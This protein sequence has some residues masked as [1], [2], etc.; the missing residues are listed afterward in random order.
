[1]NVSINKDVLFQILN[2]NLTKHKKE[3]EEAVKVWR[4]KFAV[5]INKTVDRINNGEKPFRFYSQLPVPEEHSKDYER[6]IRMV[7]MDT[8][9]ILVLNEKEASMYL[10]DDWDWR[11]SFDANT[12]T[13]NSGV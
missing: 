5:E 9:D 7:S 10:D 4:A 6:V 8:R 12:S 1:M 2:D 11:P 3:Y 13:Y